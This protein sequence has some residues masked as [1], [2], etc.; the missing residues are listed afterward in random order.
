MTRDG[1]F[2]HSP[3]A[4]ALGIG[5]I[6]AG[7]AL[8][9]EGDPDARLIE[10]GEYIARAGGCMSCHGEDLAGGYV[11]DSPMGEIVA[12]NISPSVEYGIGGYDRA[13]LERVL[14]DGVA[15]DHRLYPAMPFAS[16]RGMRDDD[17]TALYTWLMDQPPVERPLTQKTDLPFPFNIRT[18]MG[19]WS[20][21]ALG[22]TDRILQDDPQIQRGAYLVDHLGHCGECH[23]PRN[24]LFAMDQSRYLQGAM[25]DGW[26]APNLTGDPVLGMGAWSTEAIVDYLRDG[27]SMNVAQAAGPMGDLVEHATSHLHEDDL[28]AIAVY[29]QALP[30]GRDPD[31]AT[32]TQAAFLA[33]EQGREPTVLYNQIRTELAE[34]VQR[35]DLTPVQAQY[36]DKCA[37]CHG[38]DG[39]GQPSAYYPPLQ[40][41]LALRRPDPTNLVQ[42]LVHGIS[43]RTLYRAPGM[44]GFADEMDNAEIATM[45]NYLRV[46]WGGHQDSQITAD[47]VAAILEGQDPPLLVRLAPPLAW[48]GIIILLALIGWIVWLVMRRRNNTP[49]QEPTP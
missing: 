17:I 31:E 43:A 34:A 1:P 6:C 22:E 4:L 12:T 32:P 15:P 47:Y 10:E 25:I 20:A 35:T 26:L 46:T 29:L 21:V 9:A 39:N 19:L 33:P 5:L 27:H 3:L 49:A 8:S 48:A 14:R 7:P 24:A 18:G 44:P 30:S 11:I 38:V 37:A 28:T 36:L 41:N 23:T 13:D 42:V 40:D 45:A 2:S 16:Y